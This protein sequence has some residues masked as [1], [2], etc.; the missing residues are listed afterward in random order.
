MAK[1]KTE[2]KFHDFVFDFGDKRNKAAPMVEA[3]E[4]A[5]KPRMCEQGGDGKMSSDKSPA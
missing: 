4:T 2:K 3:S 1:F 5:F